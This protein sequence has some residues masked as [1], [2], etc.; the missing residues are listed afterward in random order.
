[1]DSVGV[2]AAIPRQKP[3]RNENIDKTYEKPF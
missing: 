2:P 3:R 1:M